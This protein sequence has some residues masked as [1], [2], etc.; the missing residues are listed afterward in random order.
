MTLAE[1]HALLD[2]PPAEMTDKM[3]RRLAEFVS[4][5][6]S[7]GRLIQRE[8]YDNT[9]AQATEMQAKIQKRVSD[10]L[11]EIATIE[12]EVKTGQCLAVEA[13]RRMT[14]IFRQIN[15]DRR[16]LDVL[17]ASN[18]R[19]VSMIETP[20]ETYQKEN[21]ERFPALAQRLP[22]LSVAWL[23]GEDDRDPLGGG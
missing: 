8:R 16:V 14:L 18:E 15:E 19:A 11:R 20:P 1:A 5:Y 23:S 3:K 21:L 9:L 12:H 17:D 4:R 22:V 2:D 7:Q 6:E 10:E 13:Q